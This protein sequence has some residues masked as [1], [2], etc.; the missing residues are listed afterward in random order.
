MKTWIA[1]LVAAL[2]VIAVIWLARP[3]ARRERAE[4]R[5][6]YA[7]PAAE[8]PAPKMAEGRPAP[9]VR[10]PAADTTAA[11]SRAAGAAPAPVPPGRA[12]APADTG[13]TL[14]DGRWAA[15]YW[16]PGRPARPSPLEKS[17]GYQK[18]DDPEAESTVTGRRKVGP[19]DAQLH[20]GSASATELAELLLFCINREDYRGLRDLQITFEEFRDI[21][22][23]EFPQ[24]RPATHVSAEEAWGSVM[25]S[26]VT[27][28]RRALGEWSNQDLTF[29]G[30]S[31]QQ[32]W[33]PYANFNLYLG[34]RI[35]A[36]NAAGEQVE[37]KYVDG[38]VERN[39]QWKVYIY[40]D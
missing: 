10:P 12:A 33:T 35:H 2:A 31:F 3:G 13:G 34:V 17:P 20:G 19:T 15:P 18:L 32:G 14:V 36:R 30:F 16:S 9:P 38:I 25:R 23:P 28:A 27:G 24:S 5:N 4:P 26:S 21:L 11:P 39:G 29:E 8:V 7:P 22:W 1:A 6:T 40:N 37:I